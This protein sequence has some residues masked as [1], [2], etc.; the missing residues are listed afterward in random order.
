MIVIDATMVSDFLFQN[1]VIEPITIKRQGVPHA[2]MIPYDIFE[3]MHRENRRAMRAGELTDEEVEDIRNSKPPA[4][5]DH[6]N[7]ELDD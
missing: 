1:E 5:H 3:A 4:E 2:V 6:Y 7:D